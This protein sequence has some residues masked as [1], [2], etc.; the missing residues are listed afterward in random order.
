MKVFLPYII[1]SLVLC[2][3]GFNTSRVEQISAKL[4]KIEI[5]VSHFARAHK[6][7][8]DGGIT[9][10]EINL[11]FADS[12]ASFYENEK[13]AFNYLRLRLE[14]VQDTGKNKNIAGFESMDNYVDDK[15]LRAHIYITGSDSMVKKLSIGQYYFITGRIVSADLHQGT[16]YNR[17]DNTCDVGMIIIKPDS[18]I[19]AYLGK[20][21]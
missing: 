3:C 6:T 7:W 9:T 17:R 19:Q 20:G 15:D 11:A 16:G 5:F 1:I 13:D 8:T 2:N 14:S 18:I 12:L 4:S 10:K 21:R